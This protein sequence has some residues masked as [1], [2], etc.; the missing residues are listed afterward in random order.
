M[1]VCTEYRGVLK[2]G[3]KHTRVLS[4]GG[5]GGGSERQNTKRLTKSPIDISANRLELGVEVC[6]RSLGPI[7]SATVEREIEYRKRH[8]I[9][10]LVLELVDSLVPGY[11]LGRRKEDC[12]GL[13]LRGNGGLSCLFK[14]STYIHTYIHTYTFTSSLLS[15]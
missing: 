13:E 9:I 14:V 1:F 6:S 3:E 7:A 5:G 4:R 10:P 12:M 11:L 15:D 2:L 8:P